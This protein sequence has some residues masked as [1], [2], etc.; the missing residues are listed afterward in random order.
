VTRGLKD[1]ILLAAETVGEDGK[2]KNGLHGYLVKQARTRPD[3]FMRMLVEVMQL[4]IK[5]KP[6][7]V[8]EV[9]YE[10]V[11]DLLQEFVDRHIPFDFWPP[12]LRAEYE[13][14]LKAADDLKRKEAAN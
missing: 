5:S 13:K 6:E 12:I 1:A 7:P 8:P 4:Q 3:L 9:A 2:G 11:A 10:T 14:K